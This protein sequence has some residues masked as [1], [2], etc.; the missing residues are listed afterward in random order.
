MAQCSV[1]PKCRSPSQAAFGLPMGCTGLHLKTPPHN[2]KTKERR[3]SGCEHGVRG[4]R[5]RPRGRW[6]SICGTQLGMLRGRPRRTAKL[7]GREM[8]STS[9][10]GVRSAWDVVGR[11]GVV[12]SARGQAASSNVD[13]E[14]GFGEGRSRLCARKTR[15]TS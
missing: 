15:R 9:G 11:G 10:G 2:S 3:K 4:W 7:S 6:N 14:I 8:Q 12:V 1:G 13:L 5:R